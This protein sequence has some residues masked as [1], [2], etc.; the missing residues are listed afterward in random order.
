MRLGARRWALR[1]EVDAALEL[2]SAEVLDS[3]LE[4]SPHD[5][6]IPMNRACWDT[7]AVKLSERV[8]EL[9]ELGLCEPPARCPDGSWHRDG[10]RRCTLMLYHPGPHQYERVEAVA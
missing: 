9:T 4:M 7:G 8:D 10:S 5:R 6:A 1:A 3:I 2:R